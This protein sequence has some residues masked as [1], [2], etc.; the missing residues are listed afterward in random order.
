MPTK[1]FQRRMILA[2]AV[3][4]LL[5]L[6][7][8][9]AFLFLQTYHYAVVVPG[10]LYRDGNRGV[11][12]FANACRRSGVHTVVSVVDDHEIAD[13]AKPQFNA[14]AAYLQLHGIR[15]LRIPVPLGGWPTTAD[16]Q[17]FLKI[18]NDPSDQP[19]LVHCAQGVRRTGMFVAAYQ[20]HNEH[21]DAPH[22]KAAITLFGHRD[23]T[24]ADIETFINAYHPAD[25][26]LAPLP[27]RHSRE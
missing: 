11:R 25:N 2:V 19:V 4:L 18:V 8:G 26:T 7:G 10:V 22:A 6:S 24:R 21:L 20:M 14:E 23:S 1:A 5:A 3:V 15:Q 27:T 9:V 17:K 16:V 13:P 12:E